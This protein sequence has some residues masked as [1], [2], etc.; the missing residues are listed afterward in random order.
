MYFQMSFHAWLVVQNKEWSQH[1]LPGSL[2]YQKNF[3]WS[4]HLDVSVDTTNAIGSRCVPQ[5]STPTI[6]AMADGKGPNVPSLI[7]P[8]SN[9]LNQVK[10][11]GRTTYLKSISSAI[12]NSLCVGE[13]LFLYSE[14][15]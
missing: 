11:D 10:N 1:D 7:H 6:G 14:D 3:D 12:M 8:C 5:S 9:E 2:A 4:T 13:S 15:F